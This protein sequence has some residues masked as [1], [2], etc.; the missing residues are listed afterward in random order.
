MSVLTALAARTRRLL[1]ALGIVALLT[2]A[3]AGILVPGEGR[4]ALSSPPPAMRLDPPS[5]KVDGTAGTIFTVDVI[6]EGVT[7]LGAFEFQILYDPSFVEAIEVRVGQF[8]GSTNRAEVCHPTEFGQDFVKQGCNT[9]DPTPPGPDGSGVLASV[10]F[11][12]QG[13]AVGDTILALRSC[14]AADIWGVVIFKEPC[15]DSK[16]TISPPTP[17]PTPLGGSGFFPDVGDS[18]GGHAGVVAGVAAGV[19]VGAV[20]LGG[21]AW[22]ARRRLG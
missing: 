6:I 11:S 4:S 12:V 9:E 5:M 14:E 2:T 16:L 21:A 20:A 7:N 17:T 18:S 1:V 8:L 19:A 13:L 10:D 3:T 15:K 22:Y